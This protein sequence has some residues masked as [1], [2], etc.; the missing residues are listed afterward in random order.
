MQISLTPTT[1]MLL[2]QVKGKKGNLNFCF[3]FF[4]TGIY[5]RAKNRTLLNIFAKIK[6]YFFQISIIPIDS[7]LN[8]KNSSKLNFENS[9]KDIHHSKC[10]F[11]P[12]NRNCTNGILGE[13]RSGERFFTDKREV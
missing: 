6:A 2:K 10:L 3:L 13:G 9:H 7:Y 8:S 1:K 4:E 11:F 5:K 12:K